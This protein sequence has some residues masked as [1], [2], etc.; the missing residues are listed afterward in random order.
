MTEIAKILLVDDLPENLLAL[1][2]L[3]HD[4]ELEMHTATSGEEALSLLL[5]HEFALA[6]LDVQMPGMTGF[7]LAELIRGSSRTRHLPIVFVSAAEREQSYTFRGYENGAVDFLYK[8]LDAYAVKSKVRVF[9]ELWV[10]SRELRQQLIEL[11]AARAEQQRLV[12]ALQHTQGDLQQALKMRDEFMSMVTHELRTPLGVMALEVIM[13][14]SRLQRG[15]LAWF[16]PERLQA[17]IDKDDR[18][19][20]SMTRL[21][22]DMLDISR[23]QHGMLSIRPRRTDLGELARR[24]VDDFEGQYQQGP[25]KVPLRLSALPGIVGEWDDSRI[26]QVLVNLLT[27]ALRYGE[28]KPVHVDVDLTDDGL[29]RLAV[30]D[31]G[32]GIALED[33]HKVFQQFERLSTGNTSP[34]MGLGLFISQQFVQAHGGRIAL[35][36]QPGEGACF[37]VL[38]PLMS[39]HTP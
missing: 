14:R 24:V 1:T 17:M 28:G 2:A 35:H 22:E 33:Q 39:S 5:E 26:A 12:D 25:Q 20:R 4:D 8:P 21:I 19:V 13:R 29:A 30:T 23:L 34:G 10:K 7:E 31:Q 3:L 9:T 16:S 36:S 15:D 18:Q 27:N 6:L 37:E 11:E 38:L 32:P